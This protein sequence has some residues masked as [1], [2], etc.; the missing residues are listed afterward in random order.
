MGSGSMTP[1]VEAY[2]QSYVN[3]LN[4]SANG[5]GQHCCPTTGRISHEVYR[6]GR[7]RY[8]EVEFDTAVVNIFKENRHD[9]RRH[10]SPQD[11]G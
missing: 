11:A 1:T 10:R 3:I 7:V 5:W 9:L 6:I 4:G 8:G 2:A